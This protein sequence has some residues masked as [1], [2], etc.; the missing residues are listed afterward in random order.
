MYIWFYGKAVFQLFSIF[1]PAR[2]LGS[3]GEKYGLL[4]TPHCFTGSKEWNVDASKNLGAVHLRMKLFN[5]KHVSH[6]RGDAF[7][8]LY[9]FLTVRQVDFK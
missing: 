2:L 5:Q 6:Q 4:K 8:E 9:V 7:V 3:E 1:K